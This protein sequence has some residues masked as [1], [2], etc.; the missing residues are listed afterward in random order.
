[1]YFPRSPS[2]ILV[3]TFWSLIPYDY[4]TQTGRS[5]GQIIGTRAAVRIL[6]SVGS[7]I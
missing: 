2:N 1:L 5:C 3:K 4:D 6:V 7:D